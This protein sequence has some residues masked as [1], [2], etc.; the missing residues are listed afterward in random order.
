MTKR[1]IYMI[2]KIVILYL[3]SSHFQHLKFEDVVNDPFPLNP[4]IS[5]C[6]HNPPL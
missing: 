3:T 4:N 6:S 2:T 1:P 5:H